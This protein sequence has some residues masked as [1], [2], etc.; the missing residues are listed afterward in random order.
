MTAT[1]YIDFKAAKNYA[2]N[3]KVNSNIGVKNGDFTVT[4]TFDKHARALKITEQSNYKMSIFT[5]PSVKASI[6]ETIEYKTTALP[7]KKNHAGEFLYKY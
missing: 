7:P 1:F 4:I 6:T 5:N 2:D 3:I